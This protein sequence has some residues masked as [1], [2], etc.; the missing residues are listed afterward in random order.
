MYESTPQH[1]IDEESHPGVLADFLGSSS[2]SDS[3]SSS[4]SD[5]DGS[6]KSASTAKRFRRRFR[7]RK[8]RKSSASSKD[9]PSMPSVN[10]SPSING[11]F[12]E[13]GPAFESPPT[14]LLGSPHNFDAVESGE[15]ADTD[16]APRR[17]VAQAANFKSR[18][19]ETGE[20]TTGE[21]PQPEEYQSKKR[22]RKHRKPGKKGG[23]QADVDEK[24]KAVVSEQKATGSNEAEYSQTQVGFVGEVNDAT[25]N[26]AKKPFNIRNLSTIRPALPKVLSTNVFTQPPQSSQPP[27]GL[28]A[29]SAAPQIGSTLRRASSLPD[30][31]NQRYAPQTIPPVQP[32]PH[33]MPVTS[34]PSASKEEDEKKHLSSTASI[35]LLLCSTGLVAACAEF[36][37]DSIDYLVDE[38][39]VSQAFIG[40]IILPIVGNAAEHVTAV[41]VASKNKMDLAIGVA[42]GSSIQIALFVTPII[43]LLGWCLDT[44]MSLYFSLFET[45][46]LFVSAF[47]VGFLILDGRSNYLEGALLIAAYVIIAVLAFFYPS[48]E[49]LSTASGPHDSSE[50]C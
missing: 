10:M 5:S 15:E 16:R 13:D 9:T 31:L 39:G 19:F 29:V 1:K 46:S 34:R 35:L 7:R 45:V 49:N 12:L 24:M 36:L 21:P 6:S 33:I 17:R 48:C 20:T 47:I 41:T 8:R 40:L 14:Q 25:G 11:S 27:V 42:V 23:N 18:D 38:T 44:D 37:V 26:S 22:G 28:P 32:L 30:R 2:S 4:S 3:S 43:V 50:G